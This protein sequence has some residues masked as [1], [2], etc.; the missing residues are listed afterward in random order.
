MDEAIS[1][2]LVDDHDTMRQGLG[3]LLAEEEDIQVVGEASDG[4]AALEVVK[5]MHPD[6]VI[7][8]AT[9]PGM[10]GAETTE[11]ILEEAPELRVIGLS[12]HDEADMRE[13]MIGAGAVSYLN[14]ASP[15]E[16]LLSAIRRAAD[17]LD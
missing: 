17:D 5:Q 9:M 7:M 11:A 10:S 4:R 3:L 15:P 13:R 12:M 16:E 8:D 2:V 6:V 14:K 1:V